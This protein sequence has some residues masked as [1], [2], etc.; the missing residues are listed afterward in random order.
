MI[1]G[2]AFSVPQVM[3]CFIAADPNSA[4]VGDGSLGTSEKSLS[5]D[6]LP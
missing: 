3:S 6:A 1:R 5:C 4:G 2:V